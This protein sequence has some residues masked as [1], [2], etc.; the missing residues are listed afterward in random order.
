MKEGQLGQSLFVYPEHTR[1]A[2]A[3]PKSRITAAVKSSRRVQDMLARQVDKIL[4]QYKLAPETIKLPATRSVPEI[5]VFTVVLKAGVAEELGEALPEELLRCIDSAISFPILFELWDSA[6]AGSARIRLAATCKRPLFESGGGR[7]DGKTGT[8]PEKWQLGEY[9]ASSWVPAA[10]PRAD[11][12]VAH[13]LGAL[14]ELLL[15]PLIPQQAR[16]GEHL[17]QLVERFGLVRDKQREVAR[18]QA[19]L[20]KEKQFNRKVEI[21]RQL[22]Q[23]QIELAQLK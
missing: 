3:V 2:R 12:P 5:Q 11:L 10:S 23:L 21:N 7:G 14:Y 9:F 15:Q 16:T 17:D 13:S 6:E 22:R 1:V 8:V 4:W 18:V 19:R 20:N